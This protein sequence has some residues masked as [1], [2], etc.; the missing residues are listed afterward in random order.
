MVHQRIHPQLNDRL[1]GGSW[2]LWCFGIE[3]S[4]ALKPNTKRG[5]ARFSLSPRRRRASCR[6]RLFTAD[7]GER[8]ALSEFE[9]LEHA[10]AWGRDV[11]HR[12]AQQQGRDIFYSK[13]DLKICE[14]V[15]ETA[16]NA[17]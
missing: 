6:S 9:T 17:E 15:S 4:P 8:L 3:P 14:L 1:G 2:S 11:E 16:F 5:Q 10:R 13:F 12:V 7:D